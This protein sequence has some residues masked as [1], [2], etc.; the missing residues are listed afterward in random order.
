MSIVLTRLAWRLP[1]Q[2]SLKIT[3]LALCDHAN[4]DGLCWPSIAK[5]AEFTCIS[6]RQVKRLVHA[7]VD[8]E[9]VGVIANQRGGKPGQ[10]PRYQLNLKSLRGETCDTGDKLSRV[11][12]E[13]STGAMDD[14]PRVTNDAGTGDT[15]DTLTTIEPSL[16][17]NS[18]QHAGDLA[19]DSFNQFWSIYPIKQAKNKCASRWR[20]KK[21][22]RMADV[23]IT[24]VEKKKRLDG[25][26]RRGYA[27]NPLTYIN[28]DRWNDGV[29]PD[30]PTAATHP[31]FSEKNYIGSSEKQINDL[32]GGKEN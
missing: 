6:E 13:G 27:P 11:T 19:L 4:D 29:F 1:M 17:P 26:W 8:R 22:D 25:R 18:I 5:L 2:S 10:T 3:L 32:F 12:N 31:K 14:T 23:I 21:L 20:T 28:Q 30:T 15:D 24:D 7:L 16:N 9:L